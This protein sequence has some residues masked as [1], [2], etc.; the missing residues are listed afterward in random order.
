MAWADLVAAHL[1]SGQVSRVVYGSIIGLALVLALEVHPPELRFIIGSL[2]ATAVAVA[3]AEFYSEWVGRA[4][5]ESMGVEAEPW[6]HSAADA[7]GVAFGIAFPSIFFVLATFQVM[8][9][10]TAFNW[11]IWSGL[12]LITAY[13]YIAARLSGSSFP[14]ALLQAASVGVLAGVLI[15]VKS[16]LH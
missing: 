16:L 15:I 13:G 11:A 6:R 2:W 9:V 5:R 7:A 1:R 3:F 8:E 12:G 4:T 14:K 10:G